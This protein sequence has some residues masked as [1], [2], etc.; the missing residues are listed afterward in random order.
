MD[1]VQW[2]VVKHVGRRAS[3]FGDCEKERCKANARLACLCVR[4]PVV[5]CR[6]GRLESESGQDCM[7]G[8]L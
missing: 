6:Q 3:C 5:V 7:R 8:D 2:I 4:R 1:E